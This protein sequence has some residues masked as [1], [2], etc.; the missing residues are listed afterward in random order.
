MLYRLLLRFVLMLPILAW[1]ALSI[2][3]SADINATAK[4]FDAANT[5]FHEVTADL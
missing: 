5:A 1:V 4:L 2:L 3:G